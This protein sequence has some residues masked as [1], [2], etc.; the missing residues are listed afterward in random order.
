MS[1]RVFIAGHRG[2]V[3]SAVHRLLLQDSSVEVVTRSRDELDLTAQAAVK[4]VFQTEQLDEVYLCAAKV[5]GIHASST[6]PAYSIYE[7]RM[8]DCNVIHSAWQPG[9]KKLLFL[10][11]PC[12]YSG[13]RSC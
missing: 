7:N 1:R 8:L 4:A 6:Y 10:G 3:G 5:G 13:R 12:I 11:S 2:M 9:I